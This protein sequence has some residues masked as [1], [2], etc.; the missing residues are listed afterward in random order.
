VIPASPEH[1]HR[2]FVTELEALGFAI[3]PQQAGT[4]LV[5]ISGM[6]LY[7]IDIYVDDEWPGYETRMQINW[8]I[9]E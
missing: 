6:E 4:K 1:V 7:T 2:H 3:I 8:R 9:N 5:A